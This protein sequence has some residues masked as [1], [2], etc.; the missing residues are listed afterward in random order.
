MRRL[1][2]TVTVSCCGDMH[3]IG[4]RKDGHFVYFDHNHMHVH[5]HHVM[6]EL[7][8]ELPMCLRFHKDDEVISYPD[9]PEVRKNRRFT[10]AVRRLQIRRFTLQTI[11]TK[12]KEQPG[13]G[14]RLREGQACLILDIP[15]EKPQPT[16]KPKPPTYP[17]WVPTYLKPCVIFQQRKTISHRRFKQLRSNT[18]RKGRAKVYWNSKGYRRGMR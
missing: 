11:R 10:S 14:K 8:A 6:T 17:A 18:W 2:A 15:P 5:L 13:L 3:R 4:L 16:P 1:L 12:R 7:G 9:I